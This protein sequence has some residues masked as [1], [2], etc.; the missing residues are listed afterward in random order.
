MDAIMQAMPEMTEL[1]WQASQDADALV[2]SSLGL[3]IGVP[4]VR[5]LHVPGFVAYVQ[6]ATFTGEFP[7]MVVVPPAPGW[8]APLRPYYNRLAG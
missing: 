2:L 7:P 6:P 4:V 8:L 1:S 3:L 5:K